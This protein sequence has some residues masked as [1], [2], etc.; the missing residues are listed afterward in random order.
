MDK[1]GVWSLSPAYD[2]TFAYNPDNRWLRA[3]QMTINGKNVG[4]TYTDLTESGHNNMGLSTRQ[5]KDI[6]NEVKPIVLHFSNYAD[7]VGIKGETI[8]YINS[9]IRENMV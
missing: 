1:H 5:C 8:N 3:H 6:I 2:I 7:E 4:I 9:I